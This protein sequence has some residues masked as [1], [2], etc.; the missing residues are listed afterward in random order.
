M[1][2]SPPG[3]SPRFLARKKV[4]FAHSQL[5]GIAIASAWFRIEIASFKM[6]PNLPFVIIGGSSF[7]RSSLAK[8][9]G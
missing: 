4:L 3:Y 6:H 9:G 8:K 2:A 5:A 7:L 1:K